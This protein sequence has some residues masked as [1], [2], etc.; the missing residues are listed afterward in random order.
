M[1]DV[2]SGG[3]MEYAF[4]LGTGMEYWANEGTVNP[5]TARARF[6]EGLDIILRSWSEDGPFRYDGE[7]YNYRYLNP[8]PKPFQKPR[9]KCFIVGTG[10]EET[11]SLAV[12]YDLGYSVV[13]VPIPNQLRAFGRLRELAEEKGRT[14][15][16]DDLII[17]VMAYV[18]ETDEQAVAEARPHIEKFFSW[19]HRVTP[20]F[21]VPPGYVT[22]KEFL[23]R[24]SDAALAEEHR[25]DVGRHG[26]HRAH[27]LRLARDG[28]RHDRQVVRGGGR[29][30]GQRRLR[31][32]RHAGVEDGEEHDDVRRGSDAAD[33]GEARP[34][35]RGERGRRPRAGGVGAT[36]MGFHEERYEI[37]GID[38]AVFTAG[39]G[40][41]LVFLHGAGT[42]LGFDSLLP[43]AERVRLIVPHHPGFGASADDPRIDTLR[44]RP[45]LPRPVRPARPRR[46]RA[47]RALAGRLPRVAARDRAAAAG[48]P[49][50]ARGA[51]RAL[52]RASIRRS[53]SS[54]SRTRRS[55][56]CSRPT[57]RSSPAS[58]CRR[59]PEFLAERYR[60]STSFARIAWKRPYDPKLA[61]WL[62]R[63]TMPTLV[64]WGDADSLIPV[65]QAPIW[66]AAIPNA[67]TR[68]L[69][70]LGHL[71]F[72]ES[73]EAVDAVGDFVSAGVAA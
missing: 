3:R 45:A 33:P 25:G 58:R 67:E 41:P 26:Q 61:R 29:R 40:E 4:P 54:A 70:G 13:F 49:A 22:T 1:L 51:V 73:R 5:A 43:L 10:S 38:T 35:P 42:A 23:R 66:A 6:R 18:A 8:W 20:R 36:E 15:V 32:R 34:E 64:V 53:T 56:R 44:L 21:L 30:P 69:P 52:G 7:F 60:E 47:R 14:I 16:P 72:D 24:A 19:F 11:V 55:C 46:V 28:R 12:D 37:N 65:E 59:T 57:R 27:R 9:P 39:E 71:L 63:V 50:R 17:V 31:E 48:E 2:M 68:I 62:H